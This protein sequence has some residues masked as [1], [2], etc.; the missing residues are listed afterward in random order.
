MNQSV[1]IFINFINITIIIILLVIVSSIELLSLLALFASFSLTYIIICF[2]II[3]CNV[4]V[5][6]TNAPKNTASCK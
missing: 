3:I 2:I 4:N 1:Y 5:L 6:F